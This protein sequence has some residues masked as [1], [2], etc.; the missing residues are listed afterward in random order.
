MATYKN[1]L[2]QTVQVPDEAAAGVAKQGL[3]VTMSDGLRYNPLAKPDPII[4]AAKSAGANGFSSSNSNLNKDAA[5]NPVAVPP[6]PASAPLPVAP[7]LPAAG[8]PV[9]KPASADTFYSQLKTDSDALREKRRAE[10][11]AEVDRL[12]QEFNDT[13]LPQERVAGEQRSGETR[14]MNA[15][16]GILGQDFGAAQTAKTD[17]YNKGQE[18]LKRQQQDLRIQAVWDKFDTHA[19]ADIKAMQ[20]LAISQ[21]A[22]DKQAYADYIAQGRDIV[23][24]IAKINKAPYDLI[25]AEDREKMKQMT[26][27]DDIGLMMYY[28]ANLPTAQKIEY[29]MEKLA[30]GK[31]LFYGQDPSTGELIRKTYDYD[32]PKG[33]DL[34]ITPDGTVIKFNKTTG[35]ASIAIG[36][37]GG[38]GKPETPNNDIQNYEYYQAQEIAAGREPASFTDW[39]TMDANRKATAGNSGLTSSE[40]QRIDRLSRSFSNEPAVKKYVTVAEAY[41]FVQQTPNDSANSADDQSLLYAFA[42]AND[43]DSV[44]REGEYATVQ[45]YAQSWAE[46]FGFDVKRIFSNSPFLT[47][48][49]RTN[50]KEV[51]RKKFM[52]SKT[53]YDNLANEYIT[54]IQNAGGSADDVVDYSKPYGSDG[55]GG[56]G[57]GTKGLFD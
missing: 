12:N 5:G 6:V 50:M 57:S 10:A 41:S 35:E 42:K 55:A 22:E 30:D 44:V 36:Q 8:T 13:I 48:E 26:G 56:G 2:G 54:R 47:T 45:K 23:S 28:N 51:I 52:S 29:K 21:R 39:Q 32:V 33:W 19:A 40:L 18:A 3:D 11:Q 46:Q 7:K 27:L 14:A 49:A 1:I 17:T 43:P 31:V 20:D 4:T 25:P 16:A 37:Q 34:S 24:S 53:Q 15:R 9:D 38:Y